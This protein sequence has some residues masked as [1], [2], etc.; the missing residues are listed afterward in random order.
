MDVQERLKEIKLYEFLDLHFTDIQGRLRHV[1]V[2]TKAVDE[3]GLTDGFPKLDGSSVRGFAKIEESDYVLKPDL[4][5]LGS[6]PWTQS[7]TCRLICN[8]V[9][10]E[11]LDPRNVA[12]RALIDVGRKQP[13]Y[14][15]KFGPEI[16]FMVHQA[17]GEPLPEFLKNKDGYFPVSPFDRLDNYRSAVVHHLGDFQIDVNAHHHEVAKYGQCEIDMKPYDILQAADNAVT[18]KYVVRNVASLFNLRADFMPKP[19]FDDNGNG[20]HVHSSLWMGGMSAGGERPAF[21]DENDGL[22]LSQVARYYIG[23]IL[24]H[25]RALSF[26]VAPTTNSYKRLVPGFEAPTKICWGVGNRSAVIRV[27]N[28]GSSG[29]TK[30]VEFRAPDPSC[31]PYLAFAAILAAGMDGIFKKIE[32]QRWFIKGNA[33]KALE[34]VKFGDMPSNLNEAIEAYMSDDIF[35]H[36]YVSSELCETLIDIAK[37]DEKAVNTRPHPFEQLLYGDI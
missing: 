16:E 7:R 22:G 20:M 6:I 1:T 26:I 19:F 37:E 3:A 23:G 11:D 5:T 13:H 2:P 34:S 33:Y 8:I 25:A 35:F 29:S 28:Y 31:N 10:L 32:P 12:V 18:Y 17:N 27:P 30:R 36:K 24:D 4:N 9:G 21:Y 14:W 15:T